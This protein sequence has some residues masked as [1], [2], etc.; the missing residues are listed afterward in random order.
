MSVIKKEL[1]QMI[2]K[3][4]WGP[5]DVNGLSGEERRSIVLSGRACS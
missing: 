4:V 5:V 3:K 1:K 2:D